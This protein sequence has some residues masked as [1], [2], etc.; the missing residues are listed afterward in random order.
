M[1]AL[2][3]IGI[4]L[5]PLLGTSRFTAAY[6]LTGLASS[7]TSLY[8]HDLTVSAGASGAIFGMY[9]VFLALLLTNIVEPSARKSLL[10][11]ISLFV[12]YNLLNG[13]KGGIDN[14]AHIGGLISGFVIGSAFAFDLKKFKKPLSQA[15][16]I[17]TLAIVVIAASS[18]VYRSIP[19]DIPK[20]DAMMDEFARKENIALSVFNAPAGTSKDELLSRLKEKGI[21]YW[22]DENKLLDSMDKLSIPKIL[23]NRIRLMH[24]YCNL[25]KKSFG[26]LYKMVDENNEDYKP[27]IVELNKQISDVMENLKKE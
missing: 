21:D 7:V 22:D 27:Q 17:G 3:Y 10:A 5:E 11:S 6:L 9:G 26:L 15:A 18:F 23:H 14:S 8:W 1:Y 16:V 4:L 24:E 12:G 19:N 20:Y 25:R 13:L 2:L